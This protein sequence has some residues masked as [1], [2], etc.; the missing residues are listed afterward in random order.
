DRGV[1][2]ENMYQLNFGG[3][4]DFLNML[5]RERLVSKKISKTNSVRSQL[6]H[7]LADEHIHIGPSDYVPWLKDRK[8]A[9]IRVE[10]KSFGDVPLNVELKLEVH[11]S[12][13]SA[14]IVID[15]VRCCKLGLDRGLSGTLEGPSSYFMKS[16]PRQ[17]SDTLARELTE[18]FIAGTS[19]ADAVSARGRSAERPVASAV[20]KEASPPAPAG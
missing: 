11:D 3:N 8:W 2:I 7:P 5:E 1:E 12:P 4:T 10:G 17:V 20:A 18:E 9:F 19:G 13:N 14:G 16:P 6:D 15:A